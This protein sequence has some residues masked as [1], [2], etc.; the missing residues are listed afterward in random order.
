VKKVLFS[1]FVLSSFL[2]ASSSEIGIMEAVVDDI[3]KLKKDYKECQQDLNNRFVK[4]D[5]KELEK[6]KLLLKKEK[7]K[8]VK[9]LK[10]MEWYAQIIETLETSLNQK[11]Q[12]I[13]K[14]KSYKKEK[15]VIKIVK[16]KK[17]TKKA[18]QKVKHIKPSNFRLKQDSFIYNKPNG[19]KMF[20]WLKNR[21]FTT[22]IRTDD[23]VKITGYFVNRRWTKAQ[24]DMWIEADRVL[25]RK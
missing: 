2:Y 16:S 6:Y 23:W 9:M 12:E 15:E 10:D 18:P 24:E 13:E 25:K 4:T 7:E 5:Y 1:V 8:N 14:L 17:L 20:K 11:K 21:T 22:N 19:K 3:S